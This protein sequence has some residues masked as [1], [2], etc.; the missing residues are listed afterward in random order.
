MVLSL[1]NPVFL[2]LLI[3]I[4]SMEGG[5]DLLVVSEIEVSF[6]DLKTAVDKEID[7]CM[8]NDGK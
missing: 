4:F 8:E 7:K 2:F 6:V 3:L 5:N 1:S